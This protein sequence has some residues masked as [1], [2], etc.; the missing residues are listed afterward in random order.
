[1]VRALSREMG[2]GTPGDADGF[3]SRWADLRHQEV[4]AENADQA[5]RLAARIF[6]ADDGYVI[7][8][9]RVVDAAA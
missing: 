4:I 1:M 6:P 5:R 8:E 7:T 3:D 9:V 2:E